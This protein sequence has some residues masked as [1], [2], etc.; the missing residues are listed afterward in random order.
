MQRHATP[1]RRA[2]ASG[3]QPSSP[4][5][6]A[7]ATAVVASIE[8]LRMFMQMVQT[9]RASFT[10]GSS[11]NGTGGHG[12]ASDSPAAAGVKVLQHLLTQQQLIG[13]LMLVSRAATRGGCSTGCIQ[14]Q[15]FLCMCCY[16]CS[17]R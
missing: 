10:A 13:K 3:A 5:S 6:L 1:S 9:N 17:R 12:G 8:Q 11:H 15:S 4:K 14:R 16:C 2:S 7:H